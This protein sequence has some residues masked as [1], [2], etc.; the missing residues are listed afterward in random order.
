MNMVVL[1]AHGV[2]ANAIQPARN[3]HEVILITSANQQQSTKLVVLIE[4]ADL[5]AH[6]MM[7]NRPIVASAA[8]AINVHFRW[9]VH[10]HT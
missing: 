3:G 10:S 8:P 9:Y 7:L 4:S 1:N 5:D 6:A 2:V